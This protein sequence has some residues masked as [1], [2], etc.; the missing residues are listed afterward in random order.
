M[1][2]G[3]RVLKHQKKGEIDMTTFLMFGNY[4][5]DALK[6]ISAKRTDK[7]NALIKKHGGKIKAGYCT[8]RGIRFSSYH[9]SA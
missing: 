4:S 5:Q 1:S 7:A 9:R 8:A 2:H 3:S 6:S